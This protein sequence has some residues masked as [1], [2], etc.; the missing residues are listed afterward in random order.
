MSSSH[1]AGSHSALREDWPVCA[2][3]L[4]NLVLRE[5]KAPERAEKPARIFT[6]PVASGKETPGELQASRLAQQQYCQGT[7]PGQLPR[8]TYFGRVSSRPDGW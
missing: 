7:W 8:T 1:G 4:E 6:Q 3:T 2:Q 5:G